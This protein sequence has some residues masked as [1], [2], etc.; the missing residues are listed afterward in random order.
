[1][2]FTLL[3]FYFGFLVFCCLFIKRIYRALRVVK[4]L[5]DTQTTFS[6]AYHTHT[7]GTHHTTLSYPP[8][9]L[10][11]HSNS[12]SSPLLSSCPISPL[13]LEIFLTVPPPLPSP[14]VN[15]SIGKKMIRANR[16]PNLRASPD[17]RRSPTARATYSI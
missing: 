3:I 16:N 17:K 12:L 8:K 1:M 4:A 15:V 9:S 10:N 7:K 11:L 6:P 5:L 13:S 2:I 14:P